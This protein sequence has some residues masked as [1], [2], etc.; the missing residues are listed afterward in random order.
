MSLTDPL[1][2]VPPALRLQLLFLNEN[3]LRISLS[4]HPSDF[5]ASDRTPPILFQ[6][7][8]SFPTFLAHLLFG[9]H[10]P[11]TSG[12]TCL[13]S[14]SSNSQILSADIS[15]NI[16][17]TEDIA[18]VLLCLGFAL[19]ETASSI[20]YFSYYHSVAA[21]QMPRDSRQLSKHCLACLPLGC[22]AMR[23]T[24]P[25]QFACATKLN[26]HG[27]TPVITLGYDMLWVHALR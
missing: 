27:S 22:L 4:T 17:S 13:S 20:L 12:R 15:L 19:F 26:A 3:G 16:L 6:L 23:I 18:F 14:Y 25:S 1:A 5:S 24:C 8:P 11:T 21:V 2:L 7:C 9:I 10:Q